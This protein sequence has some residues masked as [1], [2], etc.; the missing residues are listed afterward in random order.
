MA[1]R[2][3]STETTPPPASA[4]QRCVRVFGGAA[5]PREAPE[6]PSRKTDTRTAGATIEGHEHPLLGELTALLDAAPGSRNLLRHLAGVEHGLKNKD[7]AGMF[8]FRADAAVLRTALRQ[9]DGLFPPSPTRG[10]SALRARIVSAI[11]A[12]DKREKERDLLMP[13]SDLMHSNKVEIGEVSASDFDRL[14]EQWRGKPA[15]T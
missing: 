13:R 15:G 9:L 12:H 8:L 10:L 1:Q 5:Q 4:W 14:S 7:P 6:R 2:N 11:A 3:S